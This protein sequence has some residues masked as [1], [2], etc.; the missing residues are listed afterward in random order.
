M[1]LVSK[2]N[3]QVNYFIFFGYIKRKEIPGFRTWVLSREKVESTTVVPALGTVNSILLREKW[4]VGKFCHTLFVGKPC[5]LNVKSKCPPPKRDN[6][7]YQLPYLAI[8]MTWTHSKIFTPRYQII[9]VT[10]SHSLSPLL[11]Y[12]ATIEGRRRR[13]IRG[14]LR[15]LT[16]TRNPSLSCE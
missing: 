7:W 2:S 3:G 16:T 1:I 12:S 5:T 10:V 4:Y 8:K 15:N 11:L 9:T 13:H 14:H 6:G